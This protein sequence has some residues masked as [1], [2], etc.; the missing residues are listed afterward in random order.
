MG[1][2]S[3]FHSISYSMLSSDLVVDLKAKELEMDL[4]LI[5]LYG[6]Y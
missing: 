2:K 1:C 6:P 3:K 4:R 5:N